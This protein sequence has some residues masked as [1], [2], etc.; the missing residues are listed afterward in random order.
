MDTIS[1]IFTLI[2]CIPIVIGVVFLISGFITSKLSDNKEKPN[3]ALFI[4]I[5]II[6]LVVLILGSKVINYSEPVNMFRP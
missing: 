3:Y 6:I 2:I 1:I 4:I 5:F